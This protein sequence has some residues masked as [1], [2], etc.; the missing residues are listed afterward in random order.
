MHKK[1]VEELY[2]VR[3]KVAHRGTT[4]SREWGWS[5]HEHLVMA[6]HVFP[7][8]VKLL[9]V[10]EGYYTLTD[11][12]IIWGRSVDPVVAT[13]DPPWENSW[14]SIREGCSR[15]RQ[16]QKDLTVLQDKYPD[17]FR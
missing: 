2:D 8:A 4:A 12:D 7:L 15:E 10:Q 3:S 17:F 16:Q 6:A 14:D 5:I 9:L 13:V 1:W 11:A